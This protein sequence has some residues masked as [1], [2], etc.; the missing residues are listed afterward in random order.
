MATNRVFRSQRLGWLEG[1]RIFGVVSLLLYHAQLLFTGY[2]YTPQPTGLLDNL[3]RLVAPVEAFPD[4]GLLFHFLSIPPWFGFQ[5]IDVFVLISGFSFVLSQQ[6]R[7]LKVAD[8]LKLRMLRILF[9]FWTVAWLSCPILWAIGVATQTDTPGAW[10]LFHGIA[11]PLIFDYSGE[12]LR[13]IS[14]TWGFMPLI[15]SF[16][17][18]SPLL[19]YLLQRWGTTNLLLVCTFLT[20]GYRYL[21]IYQFDASPTYVLMEGSRNWQPFLLFFSQLSTFALGMV[22]AHL[23]CKGKG[24]IFWQAKRAF[25]MGISIY[26]VGFVCQFYRWG[27]VVAD[28]LLPVGIFLC[29]LVIFRTIAHQ[30]SLEFLLIGLGTHSYSYFLISSL[31]VDSVIKLVVQNNAPLYVLLLPVMIIGTLIFAVLADYCTPGVQRLLSGLLND[32]DYVLMRVPVIRRRAWVPQ[33]GDEVIY[34]GE[35]GWT[36]LKVEVLLDERE[37]L[38]CQLG[39]GQRSLW[40]NEDDLEPAGNA[41][42]KREAN[43]DSAFF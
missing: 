25:L 8:F 31:V 37:F 1:I 11:F 21:I 23:Y 34:H 4:R 3:Q 27:W 18:I 26:L 5:F 39:N 20:V 24:P 30:S 42:H 9:P 7:A 29:C 10:Q 14:E 16:A 33:V 17:L 43:K 28:L 15:L 12:A 35:V 19:W 32:M 22:V 2:A 13:S 36:V 41:Y 6:G 38:L 40:V